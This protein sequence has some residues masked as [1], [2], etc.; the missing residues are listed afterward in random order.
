MTTSRRRRS[1][2]KSASVSAPVVGEARCVMV[3]I[4]DQYSTSRA[5]F[6]KRDR[7]GVADAEV[8]AGAVDA[9]TVVEARAGMRNVEVGLRSRILMSGGRIGSL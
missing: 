4:G 7:I 5:S 6:S 8:L 2:S 9:R 1:W 3:E